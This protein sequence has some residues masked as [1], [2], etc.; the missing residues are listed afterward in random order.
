[1]KVFRVF[2]LTFI[3]LCATA[4]NTLNAVEVVRLQLDYSGTPHTLDIELFDDITPLTVANFL[5]YVTNGKYDGTFIYRSVPGFVLQTGGYTFR[6]AD[7]LNDPLRTAADLEPVPVGPLSPVKNEF[8][9]S[10]IRGTVAMAKLDGEPDSASSEWFIN[11]DDNSD[12]LDEQNG[13][14]TV[15]GN[16]IDDGMVI[17]DEIS[18]F[19]ILFGADFVLGSA[20]ADLPVVDYDFITF[21]LL[22][23]K[24]LVMIT[25]ATVI[26]RPIIRFTPADGYFG[27]DVE[28]DG[29]SK[30]I[31]VEVKNTGVEALDIGTIDFG[32]LLA[33][34]A[35]QSEDCS[36]TTL[37]PVSVTPSSVCSINFEFSPIS[38]GVFNDNIIIDYT[39][40]LSGDTFSV[41][42]NISGEG[43]GSA[44]KLDISTSTVDLGGVVIGDTRS[45]IV[46]VLNRGGGLLTINAFA[47]S[48]ADA[49]QFAIGSAISSPCSIGLSLQIGETCNIS[50]EMNPTTVGD[51]TATLNIQ[52]NAENS[53]VVL[54]GTALNPQIQAPVSVDLGV[55]QVGQTVTVAFQVSNTGTDGLLLEDFNITGADSTQFEQDTNCPSSNDEQPVRAGEACDIFIDFTPVSPGFKSAVLE[56]YTNDP[57]DPVVS[58]DMTGETG[59]PMMQVADSIFVGTSQVGGYSAVNEL[60]LENTG[61]APLDNISISGLSQTEFSQ[62]NNCEGTTVQLG[63]NETCSISITFDASVLGASTDALT[64]TSN[65]PLRPSVDITITAYGDNDTDGILSSIENAGPNSG[66]GNND[67][68]QDELQNNVVSF[69]TLDSRYITMISDDA[70][71]YG[72][73][74]I[75]QDVQLLSE[76][77]SGAPEGSEFGLGLY[78]F[79]VKLTLGVGDAVDVALFLPT[80]MIPIS[81]Y[82][83]GPTPDNTNPHWYEFLFDEA[84]QTGA[85]II[86]KVGIGTP[87]GAVIERNMIIL[88]FVDGFRGDDDLEING[89][90]VHTVGGVTTSLA[91]DGGSG[92]ALYLLFALIALV[93]RAKSNESHLN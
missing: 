40:N 64:I 62:V 37:E 12:N 69:P 76:T 47:I 84:T 86:G 7:P 78:G 21:P 59:E 35:V 50:I 73:V 22:Y 44:P 1:M 42:Y 4:S 33:P 14:F 92:S 53:D 63:N 52:A 9:L 36:N 46:E 13:G 32:S 38:L 24:N 83:Y 85:V 6:P 15:F 58:I 89:E 2:Y 8:N 5:D 72:A 66:D 70:L 30:I 23:Q 56:I 80:D 17:A 19:P 71:F 81:F 27:L 55:A 82:R 41:T 45:E 65:D 31:A 79:T 3:L 88:K 77:P 10:N 75:L 26:S 60:I 67:G 29:V 20:F 57:D 61:A 34:F 87:T 11:L 68:I 49:D 54:N 39:G 16:V 90:V 18:T 48:G 91:T 25:S 51:K 28:G 74:T 93:L 43:V